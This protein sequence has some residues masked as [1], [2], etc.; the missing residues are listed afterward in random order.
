MLGSVVVKRSNRLLILLGVLLAVA[1]GVAAIVLANGGGGGGGGSTASPTAT[2]EPTV[3]VVVAKA[4]I[5]LGDTITASMVGVQTM[6]VS[7]H[8][9]LGQDTYSSTDQVIGKIAGGK[10]TSGQVL[11]AGRDLLTP[12]S[13]AD[14]TDIAG[15]ISPGMVAVSMEVDQTNGVG[16]LIVPGDHV[17][18]ILSVYTDPLAISSKD[19]AGNTISVTDGAQALTSKML[20]QNRKVLATLV[21]PPTPG[22]TTA[23]GAAAA[24][25]TTA[26]VQFSGR[27]MIAIVEV[28]PDEAEIIRW[29]QRAE[30]QGTQNYIDLAFALRSSQDNSATDAVTPGITFKMLVD[31][32]GVLPPDPRGLLPADLAKGIQW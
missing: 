8:N 6:T 22:A 4:D 11:V 27:T 20:I 3:Q 19:A 9:A 26:L 10:I 28:S 7:Q 16:T 5:N 12:G 29:A 2:P 15:A 23:P 30:A 24:A 32:Y 25:P 13:M 18:I 1:G 14:G 21:P 31:Q 17:D